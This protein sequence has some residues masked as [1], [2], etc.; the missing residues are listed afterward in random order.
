MNSVYNC[1][2]CDFA[3]PTKPMLLSHI[4]LI[5]SND[6]RFVVTCGIGG[7]VYTAKRFSTYYS[8]IYRKYPNSGYISRKTSEIERL[9]SPEHEHLPDNLFTQYN[10]GIGVESTVGRD[11]EVQ[12]R[13][14]A[15]F[16]LKLKEARRVSQVVVDD[17]VEELSGLFEHSSERLKAGVSS[18]LA[19]AGVDVEYLGNHLD[20]VF[21]KCHN[22]LQIW[23]PDTSKRNILGNIWD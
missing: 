8:H 2:L 21:L 5:H 22:R 16:I 11:D 7:C 14:S 15:L 4:R 17:V 10:E 18:T 1:S 6:P 19:T 23:R 9:V 13:S 20:N 3:V 12:R